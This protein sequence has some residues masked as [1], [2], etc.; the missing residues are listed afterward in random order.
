LQLLAQLFHNHEVSLLRSVS[1]APLQISLL[2]CETLD[3]ALQYLVFGLFSKAKSPQRSMPLLVHTLSGHDT[4]LQFGA[5]LL[6]SG[7]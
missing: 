7:T 6:G 2:G 4:G 5:I 3:F 1:N